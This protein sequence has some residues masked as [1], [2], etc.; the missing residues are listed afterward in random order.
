[1]SLAVV[2]TRAQTGVAAPL[3]SS[4]TVTVHKPSAPI[5]VPFT[6]VAVTLSGRRR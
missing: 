4:A 5:D 6:D 3:V 2:Y 1:M